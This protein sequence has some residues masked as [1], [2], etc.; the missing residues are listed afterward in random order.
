MD[1]DSVGRR[2]G[3]CTLF[4]SVTAYQAS[5]ARSAHASLRGPAFGLTANRVLGPIPV[6]PWRFATVCL[7]PTVGCLGRS[8]FTRHQ[9]LPRCET[10]WS[11]ISRSVFLLK[12][13]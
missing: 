9:L 12:A 10:L 6:I 11:D 1:G 8:L 2:C 4:T 13:C 3:L 7:F 5:T